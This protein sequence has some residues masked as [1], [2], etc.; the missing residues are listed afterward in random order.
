MS[1]ISNFPV[2]IVDDEPQYLQGAAVALRV[3]GF[4]VTTIS[5]P[6][7]AIETVKSRPFGAI[8]LDIL[9]PGMRG[10]ELLDSL[11]S[12]SP[13]SAVIMA[14]AVND[15]EIAV[16]CMRR[17]AF[18]YLVK[19]VER[20]RLV[21]TVARA[22]E[23]VELRSENRRLKEGLLRN[24]LKSPE[25]FEDIVTRDNQMFL[26]FRY[27]EAIA[28]TPMPVLIY[29][30]TGTGKELIAKAI[31]R[32]SG[33][34]GEF[35]C[36]NAAGMTDALFNDALFGHEKG[37]FTGADSK[38]AG[39]TAKAA[40]GTLFL[41]EIG[42]IVPESQIKLLRLLEERTYYPTGSDTPRT[43]DARIIAATNRDLN[44]MRKEGKFRDDLYYRLEAHTIEIP[45]LRQR[46]ND[47]ALLIDHFAEMISR[48]LNKEPPLITDEF[49]DKCSRYDYPGNIRELRNIISDAVSILDGSSLTASTLP[50]KL[51]QNISP[52]NPA[53]SP[54]F[55]HE[56][57][58]YWQTLPAIKEAEQL[59]IEEALRRAK[60]N[61]TIAAQLLGMTRSALNKRL[62]RARLD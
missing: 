35:V 52:L 47:I 32:A 26:I 17:G 39:L 7:A 62:T 5:D 33:R 27:I 50:S 28:Q 14:T 18:D 19:P 51:T 23:M 31:H 56:T 24:Q 34:K 4:E 55:N 9:M 44:M 16:N 2:L 36:V 13:P 41:D 42:D 12:L 45:S 10:D 48:Q 59:L 21:T 37:A 25:I 57:L 40:G 22:V 11:I 58:K 30:E 8:L 53:F 6:L 46:R 29:G 54:E 61:Q 43:S 3:A 15:I 49:Y 60:G 1:N 20:D 38:R